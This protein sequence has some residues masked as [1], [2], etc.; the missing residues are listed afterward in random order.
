MQKIRRETFLKM[1]ALSLMLPLTNSLLAPL[2]FARDKKE[3]FSDE[4]LLR[5][6]VDAN[7]QQVPEL[8]Q[9]VN[10]VDGGFN[11]RLGSDFSALAAAYTTPASK[12]FHSAELVTRLESSVTSLLQF[13]TA[14]GTI[15]VGNLESPPDTAFL[16][17]L[18]TGGAYL[19]IKD[20]S[21]AITGINK[22]IKTFLVNAGEA[23][24]TGGVHTPNHR[25]VICA[26]LARLNYLY[27]NIRYVN[28]IEEW[29]DEG[30]YIDSDGHYPERSGV[31]SG[32]ENNAHITTGR[33]LNKPALFEPVR[34]NLAMMWYYM[35]PN[36]DLVTTDSRRQD[37]Y[38]LKTIVSYYFYYRQM[39]IRDNNGH[40]AA[41]A[42]FIE[43]LPA[44]E[45]EI[46]PR[47]LSHFLEDPL[48]QKEMPAATVLTT[49]YEK[50][51]ATSKLL[52]LRRG[53]R[54]ATLFGGIDW[55][56]TI[57]SG[58]SNSPNF[59]AYRNGSA[60]LKYLRL[61]SG[62]FSMGYFYSEG[63]RKEG[64]KYILHK[65]LEVPYYQPLPKKLRNAAGDYALTPS[66]DRRFWNKMDF[67]HRPVSNLK[68]LDTTVVCSET[69]HGVELDFSVTGMAG[70]TVTIE[71]CFLE[72]GLLSG[73]TNDGNGNSFLEMGMGKYEFGGEAISFG[74]G[75]NAHKN[76]TALEGENYSTHFGTL[77]T[78]GMHVYITGLTPFSHKLTF[79]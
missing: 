60:I 65:K 6:L 28:R 32:V 71:L 34:K 53:N 38:I 51:L 29:L 44:F 54:T 45:K 59:F 36:G 42:K 43:G 19:L 11:R 68:T 26:A 76:I 75:A 18:L 40:F 16:V 8:L 52:R 37:Q 22:N 10:T 3:F 77:R 14:D 66:I 17:E 72:G 30:V 12:Y 74:R 23:I 41:V 70:V 48:L 31:Y 78:E 57:A 33:L 35:E 63:I 5:R 25:W 4:N 27:P 50:F 21:E 47:G 69:D 46:L 13:Q 7:D 64:S 55:P 2:I 9:N 49:D 24:T 67:S 56:L 15:N 79:T 20:H 61:S 39:A 58:R 62:F 1:G 73:V